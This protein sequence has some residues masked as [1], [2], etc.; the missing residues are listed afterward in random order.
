MK[1]QLVVPV[2]Q[3][4][5][6]VWH[7]S[8]F[9]VIR[10][11][12]WWP[13]TGPSQEAAM[14]VRK[15]RGA[16]RLALAGVVVLAA[17][18]DGATAPGRDPEIINSTDNFQYQI[19]AIQDFSGTQV[20]SWQNTGAT[21]TVNQAATVAAGSATLVLRDA[22]GVEVYNRSLADN[23]TFSSSAGAAGSWT[24]RVVYSGADATV[25]FRVDKAN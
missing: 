23:G 4:V 3:A 24:V 2:S 21:A 14:E 13:G 9:E 18:G 25:N 12:R 15:L 19:T 1:M 22:N 5:I 11:C 6:R 10:Y 17:C 16:R 8:C 7:R 20:Y